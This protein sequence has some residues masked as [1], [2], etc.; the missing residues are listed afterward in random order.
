M[1]D[2]LQ[3]DCTS[4]ISQVAE[5]LEKLNTRVVT[6]ERGI[7]Q[8]KGELPSKLLV[9]T[10][11]LVKEV[12]EAKVTLEDLDTTWR[13]RDMEIQGRINLMEDQVKQSNEQS[14]AI[15]DNAMTLIAT[16]CEELCKP[17][18]HSQEEKFREFVLEEFAT[19]KSALM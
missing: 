15:V 19:V 8:F 2:R 12:S 5:T 4:R 14:L 1:L 11:A 7:R 16:E 9:D 10:A 13:T 17:Q 6:L 3:E 18:D